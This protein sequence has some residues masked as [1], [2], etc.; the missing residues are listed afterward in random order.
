MDQIQRQVLVI[1]HFPDRYL[2]SFFPRIIPIFN[3]DTHLYDVLP[4]TFDPV[5][6]SLA[7]L[8]YETTKQ[9]PGLV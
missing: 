4:C 9:S 5:S 3:Q 6:L 1:E 7:T 8:L 2:S